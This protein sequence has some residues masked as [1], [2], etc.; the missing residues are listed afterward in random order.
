[1]TA[2]Q[3]AYDN[4]DERIGSI[5]DKIAKYQLKALMCLMVGSLEL[6][7]GW[8]KKVENC[9]NDR[10]LIQIEKLIYTAHDKQRKETL[11]LLFEKYSEKM[12]LSL[13]LGKE[14]VEMGFMEEGSYLEFC[15]KTLFQRD[16]IKK[17]CGV[18]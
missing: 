8:K 10:R 7:A 13:E 4:C 6:G 16:F 3:P 15:R 14:E 18:A 1:M 17:M 12:T 5:T 9:E 11:H 2:F